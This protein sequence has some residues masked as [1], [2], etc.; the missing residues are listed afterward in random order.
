MKKMTPALKFEL[1]SS[2]LF[3]WQETCMI[4]ILST[5]AV[6]QNSYCHALSGFSSKITINLFIFDTLFQILQ[7]CI[8]NIVRHCLYIYI[9]IIYIYILYIYIIYIFIYILYVSLYIYITQCQCV[10]FVKRSGWPTKATKVWFW[11][12]VEDL[13]LNLNTFSYFINSRRMCWR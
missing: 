8:N 11:I 9:Y 10:F 4:S 13:K 12:V 5:G 3:M 7:D 6:L 1:C 2:V